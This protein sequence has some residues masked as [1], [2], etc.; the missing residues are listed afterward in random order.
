[1]S[2]SQT[3]SYKP[4]RTAAQHVPPVLVWIVLLLVAAGAFAAAFY[5]VG[6]V[7][8]VTG[9]LGLGAQS[10]AS[11]A[12]KP[13]G[14]AVASAT[15]STLPAEA[16]ALMYAEQLESQ[17]YLTKLANGEVVSLT[18]GNPVVTASA[19]DVPVKVALKDGTVVNGGLTLRQYNGVWYFVSIHAAGRPD[20]DDVGPSTI[21]QG[22]VRVI[23]DEQATPTSQDLIK[24]GLLGGGY[25]VILINGDVAGS[26]TK[27]V[28]VDLTGGSERGTEH[29]RF[30][31][32]Q[33]VD[34]AQT[35]WFV[36]RFEKQ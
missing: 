12:A 31:L 5:W 14:S 22:V 15:P 30:V 25:K 29:G 10:G 35:Y 23:T 20:A 28:N 34:G 8:G 9:L 1:M 21:D 33:K 16:Q 13:A 26:G 4:A 32:I 18:L 17:P 7:G 24:N 19:A 3:Q 2:E 6:G 11:G 27:T 36:A